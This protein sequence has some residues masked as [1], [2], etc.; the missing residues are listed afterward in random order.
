MDFNLEA[1]MVI[2]GLFL[3]VGL[4]LCLPVWLWSK[5]RARKY[6]MLEPIREENRNWTKTDVVT[7]AL[8]MCVFGI[9]AYAMNVYLKIDQSTISIIYSALVIPTIYVERIIK[10]WRQGEPQGNQAASLQMDQS[11]QGLVVKIILLLLGFGLMVVG[12]LIGAGTVLGIVL[13]KSNLTLSA[14]IIVLFLMGVV[15][16]VCG[17]L[18]FR[19]AA[20]RN[21]QAV[22]Q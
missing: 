4:I 5:H 1:F 16:V 13:H 2:G 18:L 20:R 17:F 11:I 10:A 15:P 22:A 12:F 7:I 21:R 3:L 8:T 19:K 9:L 6:P 14:D